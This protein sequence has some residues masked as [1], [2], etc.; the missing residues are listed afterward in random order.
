MR[1]RIGIVRIGNIEI[2]PNVVLAPMAG[3]TSHPFRVICKRLGGCGLVVTELISSM[4]IHY[5]NERTFGMFDWSADESPSFCQLFGADPVVMAE[6]ARIVCDAGAD[7]VDIN[8]GCWVPKVAKTGAGAALLKD[9]CQAEAVLAAVIAAVP[10]KPVTVKV[11][12]GF[13]KP[14]ITAI[15]FAKAAAALGAKSIAVHARFASQGFSGEADW[16]IIARVKEA[17]GDTMPVVGN[18]DIETP[19]DAARMIAETGCDAVMVGRAAMGNPWLLKQIA[20]HLASGTYGPG[21]TLDERFAV[22]RDH[23]R[24]QCAQQGEYFGV[25]EL[26][27]LLPHYFKG[28]P[29]AT[30]LR[31]ALT[32]AETTTLAQIEAILDQAREWH[33]TLGHKESEIGPTH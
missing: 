30:R 2:S 24:L 21:P 7:G 27:G 18:G 22:A 4:A 6:A 29:G 17:V 12:A 28:I 1:D 20:D 5:K 32:N 26:R 14:H 8:M 10:E 3:I 19:E 15:P 31:G 16:S 33:D 13:E 23:A 11:R 25:R 9:V